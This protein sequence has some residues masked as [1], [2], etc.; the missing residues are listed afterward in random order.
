MGL[1]WCSSSVRHQRRISSVSRSR[2]SSASRADSK[3]SSTRSS[4]RRILAMRRC[5]SRMVCRTISV[6]WAVNTN[7]TS[8]WS[9][10]SW[11]ARGGTFRRCSLGKRACRVPASR[12][13]GSDRLFSRMFAWRM[14]P[15]ASGSASSGSCCST[16]GKSSW[17][18]ACC[19]ARYCC[20]CP[21]CS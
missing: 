6:G 16:S 3:P 19:S 2:K 8:S 20:C 7:R 15:L 21:R 14:P 4:W 5:L 17:I 9:S 18:T 11:M 12:R 13:G 10:M 1:N